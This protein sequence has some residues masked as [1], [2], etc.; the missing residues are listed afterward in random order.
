MPPWPNF[1]TSL[2]LPPSGGL[3]FQ[4][5]P[6][7]GGNT[8][9]SG[10]GPGGKPLPNLGRATDFPYKTHDQRSPNLGG[11]VDLDSIVERALQNVLINGNSY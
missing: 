7:L 1:V 4:P 6:D 5:M 2:G 10:Y 11:D 3:G 9:V 8:G